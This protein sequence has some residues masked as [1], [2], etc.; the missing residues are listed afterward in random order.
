[1]KQSNYNI[2]VEKDDLH[3]VYN[4]VSGA[5]LCLQAEDLDDLMRYLAGDAEHTVT[6]ASLSDYL[7]GGMVI[8]DDYDELKVLEEHY[9]QT[10]R[11]SDRLGLTVLTSLGCN[12]ECPY[13]FEFKHPSIMSVE[14]P[15][16]HSEDGYRQ[17]SVD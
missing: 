16:R 3:Y 17:A 5:L 14:S 7:R 11:Q 4:G 6:N 10:R 9:T 8:P 12:F 2:W 1:M 15:G 13:C